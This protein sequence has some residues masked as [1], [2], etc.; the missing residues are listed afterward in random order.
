M[1]PP[2]P[3]LNLTR[4]GR[5]LTNRRGTHGELSGE[6]LTCSVQPNE[7]ERQCAYSLF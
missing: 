3:S 6:S 1:L 5:P 2:N 4:Y 7:G